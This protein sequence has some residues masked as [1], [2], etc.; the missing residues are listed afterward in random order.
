MNRSIG[1]SM[2]EGWIIGLDALYATNS[3]RV[4]QPFK[5]NTWFTDWISFFSEHRLGYQL[6]FARDQYG[7]AS[8]YEKGQRLP[9][10]MPLL[11]E[12]NDI[13][14]CLLHGDLWNGNIIMGNL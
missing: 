8:I 6:K 4:P 10:C 14:P 3:I 7:D 2:F 5:I 12:G 1:P 13:E 9:K 11:F